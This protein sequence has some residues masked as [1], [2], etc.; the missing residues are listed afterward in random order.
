MKYFLIRMAQ[1]EELQ[2]AFKKLV[3][4]LFADFVWSEERMKVEVRESAIRYAR[5]QKLAQAAGIHGAE[6]AN[7]FED[8]A[9]QRILKN[10]WIEQPADF[11]A[12]S[13]LDQDGAQKAQRVP[14]QERPASGVGGCHRSRF[15]F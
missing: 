15:Y 9:A 6:L 10:G 3:N 14:F 1:V 11:A 5:W 2:R 12:R 8:D 7:F 13:S 4:L